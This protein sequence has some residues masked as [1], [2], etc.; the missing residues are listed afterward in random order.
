MNYFVP[1][2]EVHPSSSTLSIKQTFM[3]ALVLDH[4]KRVLCAHVYVALDVSISQPVI[5]C[6]TCI[7]SK[8]YIYH[9]Q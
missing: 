6:Y 8:V 4:V 2:D 9:N 1:W 5:N 7:T 3:S